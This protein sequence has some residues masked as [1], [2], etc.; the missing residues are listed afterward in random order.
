MYNPALII[1]MLIR[2]VQKWEPICVQILTR[3]A[4]PLR[5]RWQKMTSS[6]LSHKRDNR[7]RGE[8]NGR[9]SLIAH[10]CRAAAL[11]RHRQICLWGS[12]SGTW[13]NR[14]SD[15]PGRVWIWCGVRFGSKLAWRAYPQL[16]RRRW[17]W[18]RSTRHSRGR[19]RD[20]G[21]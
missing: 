4:L 15:S 14:C 1:A 9:A 21:I 19:A 8:Q 10:D 5:L 13:E 12:D 2:G 7:S 17:R 11:D 18:R 6:W 3:E 20:H 16:G